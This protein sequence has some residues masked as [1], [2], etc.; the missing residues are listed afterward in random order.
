MDLYDSTTDTI[1]RLSVF[2]PSALSGHNVVKIN[3][4]HLFIGNGY[5]KYKSF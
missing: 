1:E 2:M 4:T 3:D 5:P